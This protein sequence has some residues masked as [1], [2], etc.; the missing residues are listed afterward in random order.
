MG[1]IRYRGLRG[2]MLSETIQC[3]CRS[4]WKAGFQLGARLG[5]L[6]RTALLT[7]QRS[8]GGHGSS[9]QA[10]SAVSYTSTIMS[11]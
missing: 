3:T 11:S 2:L 1:K 9:E 8:G 6:S 10:S 4:T 7:V 5:G